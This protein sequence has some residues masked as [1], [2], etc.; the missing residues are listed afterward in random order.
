LDKSPTVSV[1]IPTLADAA[2][3]ESLKRAVK[4]IRA[5]AHEAVK[6]IAVVNGN[7]F[8][9]DVCTWLNR[10]PDIVFDQI[11]TASS[12]VA[13]RRGRYL[14]DTEYF[15]FLDD[16]D[17]YL[18]GATDLK[19]DYLAQNPSCDLVVCNGF[20][21]TSGHDNIFYHRL[22]DISDDPLA[23][24]FRENWL[25]SCNALFRTASISSEFFEN[26]HPYA[27]WTWLAFR[28][29]MAGKQLAAL[30]EPGF[31]NNDT[32]G[33]LGKSNAYKAI[34][35]SLYERMLA[36]SPPTHIAKTIRIR[37][38]A[39][40]HERSAEA[41]MKGMWLVASQCHLRSLLQPGGLRYLA[42]SRRLLPGW[43]KV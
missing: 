22:S 41:L 4:S 12:P 16:D 20:R 40:W 21:N 2:R 11:E 28:L 30:D 8:D 39:A 5:S 19:L 25:T 31:R 32:P 7:R 33:S 34:C 18:L 15:A 35:F 26:P 43:P 6:I 38:G 13:Q 23:A 42:Y 17:E 10:Q 27:E 29:A 14:V 37:I 36:S 9:T 1:I 24:L 3:S